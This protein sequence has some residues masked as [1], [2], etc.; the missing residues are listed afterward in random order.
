[1][2]ETFPPELD[3]AFYR[4]K[5]PDLLQFTDA[6]LESHYRLHGRSEGRQASPAAARDGFL[7]LVLKR[8]AGSLLEIGPFCRP[9]ARGPHVT[10]LDVLDSDGLRARA[11]ALGIDPTDC[12]ARVDYVGS[13]N[14]IHRT[15]LG[16]ITSHSI[17]H[18]PDL[19]QHFK[20]VDRLLDTGGLYYLIIPDKRYCFD[21][22]IAPST[23]AGAMQ[24][25]HERRTRH[26]LQSVIEHRAL[27]V[28]NDSARHWT[29]E[30]PEVTSHEISVRTASALA[31]YSAAGNHYIDVHAWYFTPNSF[32]LLVEALFSL[33]KI[34]LT[35][36]R[37]YNTPQNANEFCAV[38]QKIKR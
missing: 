7:E 27:T 21:A 36:L 19:I 34:N 13:T 8:H 24:A 29:T 22:N 30:L 10:Y 6:A 25:H 35:P 17:E 14:Q 23:L 15:F 1:M 9:V 5:Y 18:Q 32:R 31:E 16:V 26:T 2:L 4:A 20:E 28:H 3:F 12:P 38:L 37:I 33:G 11:I